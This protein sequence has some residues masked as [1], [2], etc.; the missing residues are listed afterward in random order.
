L[1]QVGWNEDQISDFARMQHDAQMTGYRAQYPNAKHQIVD[2]GETSIGRMIVDRTDSD[3]TLVD[4]TIRS[5]FR[6]QGIGTHL[7]ETLLAEARAGGKQVLLSVAEGNPARRL[8]ERL[9]F[10]SDGTD[11]I[12]E[13]MSW[14]PDR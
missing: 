4:I 14:R 1:K 9:G 10:E 3:I 12:Y 11:G 5:A 2:R 13:R 8:Y 6:K 7:I